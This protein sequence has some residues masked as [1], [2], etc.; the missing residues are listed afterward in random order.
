[1]KSVLEK[2]ERSKFRFESF[3]KTISD[4]QTN[5]LAYVIDE[6]TGFA[7]IL[8]QIGH[9]PCSWDRISFAGVQYPWTFYM[10]RNSPYKSAI[11]SG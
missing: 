6:E 5:A 7:A 11:N 9:L 2:C 3:E 8:S 4:V 1:M 10:R